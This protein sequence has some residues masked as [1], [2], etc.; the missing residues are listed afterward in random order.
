MDTAGS[1]FPGTTCRGAGCAW[2]HKVVHRIVRSLT[3]YVMIDM[4][5]D[6]T[7]ERKQLAGD[8]RRV[9]RDDLRCLRRHET[10]GPGRRRRLVLTGVRAPAL[11]R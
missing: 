6:Q 5:Q 9:P 3:R 1:G 4:V 2:A 7:G 10:A 8:P 11:E